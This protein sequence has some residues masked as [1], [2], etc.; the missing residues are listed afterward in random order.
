AHILDV[1][2]KR[3]ELA[4]RFQL[5][6]Q[7]V[8]RGSIEAV[9]RQASASVSH[10]VDGDHVLGFSPNSM[11]GSEKHL[12][13]HFRLEKQ[14]RQMAQA[15]IDAGRVDDCTDA[16]SGQGGEAIGDP[17][18]EAGPDPSVLLH[19]H[20]TSAIRVAC[21]RASSLPEAC[22][23]S[24]SQCRLRHPSAILPTLP[25][26]LGR[27]FFAK[28]WSLTNASISVPPPRFFSDSFTV[29]V[30]PSVGTGISSS[31][32]FSRSCALV[33]VISVADG[34]KYRQS[35]RMPTPS[36]AMAETCT[37]LMR[38]AS[39]PKC[40]FSSFGYSASRGRSVMSTRATKSSDEK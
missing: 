10:L 21:G 30:V 35:N 36:T 14:I 4:Q 26:R 23:L 9:H 25:C 22:K 38:K 33:P 19:R 37:S 3:V 31:T 34:V 11:L 2:D 1:E 6:R 18:V 24:N 7:R 5:W 8:E 28:R 39:S 40:A 13:I 29:N 17:R 32:R 16:L 20:S 27:I 15:R 12:Q